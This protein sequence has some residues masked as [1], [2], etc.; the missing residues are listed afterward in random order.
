MNSRGW[1]QKEISQ[2]EK[3][4]EIKAREIFSQR[5]K[6]GKLRERDLQS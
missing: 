5:K 6:E 2:K 4:F 1:S 3:E